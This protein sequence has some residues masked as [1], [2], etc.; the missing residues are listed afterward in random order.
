[1]LVIMAK[2]PQPGR[3]KTRMTPPLTPQRAAE[4][5]SSMLADTVR[6]AHGAGVRVAAMVPPSDA[7]EVA[8]LLKPGVE[9]VAQSGHGLADALSTV[10]EAFAARGVTRIVAVDSDSPTLPP[11]Q[12]LAAFD[13][14]ERH[15]VVLGPTPDGGYYLVGARGSH[16][17]LFASSTTGTPSAL[18]AV[19]HAASALGLDSALAAEWYDVDTASDLARLSRD[20]RDDPDTAPATAALLSSWAADPRLAELLAGDGE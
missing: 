4:L 8:A 10:F 18:Q 16:P 17:G 11:R 6:L 1:M 14:L 7:A 5:Y 13:L 9:V 3:V 20:L 15:E 12:L 2:A 19:Q